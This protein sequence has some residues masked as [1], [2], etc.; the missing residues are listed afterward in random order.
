MERLLQHRCVSLCH[1]QSKLI[2]QDNNQTKDN[3]I[4]A[5][6]IYENDSA[7]HSLGVLETDIFTRRETA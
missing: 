3:E 1:R 4:A 2:N 7:L 5:I 6:K